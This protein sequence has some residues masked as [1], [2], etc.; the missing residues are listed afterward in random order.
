MP[1]FT[2]FIR[3]RLF[4]RVIEIQMELPYINEVLSYTRTAQ[5]K[6]KTITIWY[7][8]HNVVS[9][10]VIHLYSDFSSFDDSAQKN[11][12]S[13]KKKLILMPHFKVT[14]VFFTFFILIPICRRN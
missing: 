6:G 11:I 2:I 5:R 14:R 9:R 4:L 7:C 10:Y 3:L 1:G 8:V 13:L 12:I